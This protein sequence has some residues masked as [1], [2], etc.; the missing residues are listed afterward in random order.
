MS[1]IENKFASAMLKMMRDRRVPAVVDTL[2]EAVIHKNRDMVVKQREVKF[3]DFEAV[4]RLKKRWGLSSDT[5]PNWR[6][7]WQ[8]NAA[9]LSAKSPLSMGWV[10]EANDAIVGYLGSIPLLYHYGN[11]PLLAATASGFVVE[12]AYRAL[13][14]GLVAS[15]YRQANIELFLNTSAIES[16]GKLARAFQADAL[17]QNDYDTVLFW[18]LNTRQ[19]G[20]A[21][22]K[23][24]GVRPQLLAT[25]RI[26]CSLAL[27]VEKTFRGRHPGQ[28][29]DNFEVTEVS[30]SEI[31]NDFEALWLRRLAE[32]PRLLADRSPEQLRWHFTIPG[33]GQETKVFRS[34][35]HGRLMGYAVVRSETENETGL[36]RSRLS[37]MLVEA[38]EPEVVRSLVARAY[39]YAK[40]SG[41][42]VFEV[43]GF[44]RNL[45]RALMGWKPYFRKYPACPFY[46]KARDRA[47][48]QALLTEDSWYACPFDGDTTLMP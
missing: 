11:R 46:F 44:P 33:G 12:P 42:H 2:D 3:S 30:L 20:N 24:F 9:I 41:N 37:D 45:R 19:F 25:G 40:D 31:G 15:F 6:R 38:D 10:L 14:I 1:S 28:A 16:V 35:L 29:F 43:L 5:L 4:A 32:K 27:W 13:S 34:D 17:P 23:K 26:I 21:L 8:N 36:R 39:H 22:L 47:L 18:V 48:H 7:F